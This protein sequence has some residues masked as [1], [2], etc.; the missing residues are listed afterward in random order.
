MVSY[1]LLAAR[2]TDT[3]TLATCERAGQAV[4]SLACC[5]TERVLGGTAGK[6]ANALL[7]LERVGLIRGR[8]LV[9]LV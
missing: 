9:D 2:T 6:I 1:T 3:D 8:E 4:C 7:E 5:F